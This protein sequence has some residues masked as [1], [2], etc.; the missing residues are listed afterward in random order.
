MIIRC[1]VTPRPNLFDGRGAAVVR[2]APLIGVEGLR[3]CEVHDLFFLE[4]P[5]LDLATAQQVLQRL[6]VDPVVA[7]GRAFVASEARPEADV[8]EVAPL[9]GT[10]DTEAES[11]L[12]AIASVGIQGVA[13]AATGKRYRIDGNL[14]AAARRRLAGGLLANEVVQ[15]FSIG[16]PVPPPFVPTPAAPRQVDLIALR[17]LSD[18]GLL[19]LSKERRLSLDLTEMKAIQGIFARYDRDPTDAELEMFAQTWSEHCVHKT[20]KA[21]ITLDEDGTTT[22]VDSMFRTYIQAATEACDKPWLVSVFVDNAGIIHFDDHFDLAFKV[23]THNHPSALE[24][25][26]GANTGVGGVIRDVIGVSA[27]PIATT[28]VLCFGPP[29]LD[30]STLPEGVLHPRRIAAGVVAGVGDYGNKMGIPTVNGAILYEPGYTANPLV[31]CGCLGLLPRGSHPRAAQPGDLVVSMGGRTGRDGLRGATFSSM[32]MDT[33][34]SEIAGASVQI[35]HPIHE[36]QV[37]EAIMEARDAGLY[38]A[39]TDCGAGGLSSAVGEM[40]EKL[41]ARIFLERVPLK[42]PGLLPWEIWLSEAQER[43]VLAVP[44]SNWDA[45]EA[46][47]ARHG[48]EATALGHFTGD[49]RLKITCDDVLVADLAMPDLHDGIPQR[50]LIASWRTPSL[51]EPTLPLDANADLLALLASYDIRSKEDVVR[52]YDHEVQGGTVVKPFVGPLADGP[53]DAA[54]LRPLEA[55]NRSGAEGPGVALSVGV[56]PRIG[57]VDPYKMAWAAVD[58]AVRNAVCVGADPDHLAIL[59]NFCWG[60]PNL[61]DRLGGLVRCARGCYDA[62]MAFEAPYIS[63]KDSLNNEYADADGTRHAIPGTLLVS[64]V[65]RVPSIMATATSDFKAEGDRVLVVGATA[66]ELG[67]SAWYHLHGELGASAPA[68]VPGAL[69][70]ARAVHRLIAKGLV[71]AA[72]DASEGGLVVALAEMALAGRLGAEVDLSAVPWR[73]DGRADAPLL[74]AE[75]LSRYVLTVRSELVDTVVAALDGVPC[76]VVGRVGGISL[77]V[78]GLQGSELVDLSVEDLADAFMGHLTR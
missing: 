4:G 58:E 39:I 15:V 72:H 55:V 40:A 13:R 35:G 31:Y 48:V 20:F 69:N 9:P 71:T 51:T 76:G 60:N 37:L 57:L 41:G 61:P 46:I 1:E 68:P 26:G 36:K 18:D 74:F 45:L 66:A 30:A 3:A 32:E 33:G 19:A 50:K 6:L 22:V 34:T 54:V 29:D 63:G 17:G 7:E 64:A 62:A 44:E 47:C 21:H 56:C 38:T 73:G 27:R 12:G 11:L 25:F 2:E 78:T 75:S 53:S 49:A 14:D 70:L 59:D 65:A 16:E 5:D 52:T 8:I 42:Y 10:T 24:P 77:R 43:M 23:E 67:G 28:D